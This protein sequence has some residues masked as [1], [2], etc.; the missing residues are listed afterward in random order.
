MSAL[1]FVALAVGWAAYLIPQALRRDPAEDVPL[2]DF[3][4]YVDHADAAR[5]LPRTSALTR[6]ALAVR[7]ASVE[8]PVPSPAARRRAIRAA[9]ASARRRRVVLVGLLV[10]TVVVATL[11]VLGQV[12]ALWVW[13]PGFLVACWLIVCRQAARTAAARVPAAPPL[14]HP[15]TQAEDV[16]AV[17]APSLAAAAV[18]TVASVPEPEVVEHA[19]EELAAAPALWDPVPVTLPTYVTK[20]A[21]RRTVRTIELTGEGVTSSGHDA[22]DSAL[23]KG[24]RSTETDEPAQPQRRQAA[25]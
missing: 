1:I 7:A 16:E 5:V 4:E 20:P 6:E 11:A 8:T 21:A 22:A 18:E 3:A 23:A 24:A 19:A 2:T 15:S 25:G 10:V 12:A 13:L 9:R 14:V 17:V